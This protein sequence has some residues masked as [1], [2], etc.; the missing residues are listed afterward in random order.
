MEWIACK[1]RMPDTID[2]VLTYSPTSGV[3]IYHWSPF[4]RRGRDGA[5]T[6]VDHHGDDSSS[7][8][9]EDYDITHWMPMPQAPRY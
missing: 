7:Y 4:Y 2:N 1:D 6:W 8:G 3:G 5:H 9:I